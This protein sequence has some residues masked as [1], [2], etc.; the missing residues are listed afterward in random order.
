MLS[1]EIETDIGL[2]VIVLKYPS[3]A[4][5]YSIPIPYSDIYTFHKIKSLSI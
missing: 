2:W 3:N 5:I 4:L 1:V